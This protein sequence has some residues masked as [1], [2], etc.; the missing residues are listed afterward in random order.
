MTIAPI[1]ILAGLFAKWI[2]ICDSVQVR[3]SSV[4]QSGWSFG[5]PIGLSQ[6]CLMRVSFKIVSKELLS[7]EAP[8]SFASM[9]SPH[10]L[11]HDPRAAP[12]EPHR[13]QQLHLGPRAA[14]HRPRIGLDA[15]APIVDVEPAA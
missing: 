13:H 6:Y 8:Y 4:S 2:S 7:N 11:L 1:A 3:V 10:I 15:H 12:L 5:N 9:N 14:N